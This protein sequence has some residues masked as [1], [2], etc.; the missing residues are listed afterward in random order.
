MPVS[1]RYT[2]GFTY[3][4]RSDFP[5]F[6]TCAVI[7]WIDVFTRKEYHYS[8]TDSMQYCIDHKGLVVYAWCLMS[9]HIHL[10][11]ATK[12]GHRLSDI[13]RDFKKFTSKAVVKAIS[14]NPEESRQYW[15][16]NRFAFRA[17]Y[18]NRHQ[19]FKFWQ[20]GLHAVEIHTAALAKQKMDYIHANPVKAAWVSEPKQDVFSSAID[21]AGG[22]GLVTIEHLL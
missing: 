11:A 10:I 12:E 19:D 4:V 22:K 17:S 16:L 7:D 20:E 21:Y 14:E 8:V 3:T 5:H 2:M 15:L 6:I 13:M 1:T 18:S 9:N